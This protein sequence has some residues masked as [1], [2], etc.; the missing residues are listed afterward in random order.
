M[1]RTTRT[2]YLVVFQRM[3][4]LFD[5]VFVEVRFEVPYVVL[6]TV[7][8]NEMNKVNVYFYIDELFV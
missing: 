5:F 8:V 7:L 4:F 3:K 2:A 1:N 6:I